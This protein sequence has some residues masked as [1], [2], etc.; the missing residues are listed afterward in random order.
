M[1]Y[2][3]LAPRR[4]SRVLPRPDNEASNTAKRKREGLRSR[5]EE[6][7]RRR[8]WNKRRT[9]IRKTKMAT[10]MELGCPRTQDAS[11]RR[12]GEEDTVV[13]EIMCLMNRVQ[14]HGNS[15]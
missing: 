3:P 10:L 6:K 13:V 2:P 7:E 8:R 15:N 5:G 12:L 11:N 1:V 9:K 4:S 14:A